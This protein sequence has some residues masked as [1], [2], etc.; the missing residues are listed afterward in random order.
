MLKDASSSSFCKCSL[1]SSTMLSLNTSAMLG[2]LKDLCSTCLVYPSKYAI[3]TKL[4]VNSITRLV[5]VFNILMNSCFLSYWSVLS[6]VG[7]LTM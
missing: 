2:M 1:G 5:K 7:S 4:N 6:T 3:M